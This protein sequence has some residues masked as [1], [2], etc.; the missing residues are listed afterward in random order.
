MGKMW[1]MS[2]L[3]SM[4]CSL[5]YGLKWGALIAIANAFSVPILFDLNDF[6]ID[7]LRNGKWTGSLGAE[8]WSVLFVFGFSCSLLPSMAGG[9]ALGLCIHLLTLKEHKWIGRISTGAGIMVGAIVS[10]WY[11]YLFFAIL[12]NFSFQES[13]SL[14]VLMWGWKMIMFIWLSRRLVQHTTN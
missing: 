2:N 3:N 12:W 14:A 13:W 6:L 8:V 10:T 1:K 9:Y 4:W 5:R 11:V 7:M